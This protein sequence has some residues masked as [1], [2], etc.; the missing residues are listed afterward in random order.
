MHVFQGKD[1]IVGRR[2]GGVIGVMSYGGYN[3]VEKR[4]KRGKECL[5][6]FTYGKFV[7]ER[8]KA[9]YMISIR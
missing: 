8:W 7:R 6:Q 4:Q 3:K 1:D 9:E 5:A 2:T